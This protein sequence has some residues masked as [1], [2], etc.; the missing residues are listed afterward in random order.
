MATTSDRDA[1]GATPAEYEGGRYLVSM[2]GE[3]NWVRNVRANPRA[4]LLRRGREEVRLVEVAPDQCAPI[5]RK[6]LEIAP[7]ARAHFPLDQHAPL[8]EFERIADRYPV[9]R[10][11]PAR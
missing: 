6:Y 10:A 5:L 7:G 2:L 11:E 8:P 1:V 9:F 3:V 4:A